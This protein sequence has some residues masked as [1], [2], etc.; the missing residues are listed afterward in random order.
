MD[1]DWCTEQKIM[2]S[3]AHEY[4]TYLFTSSNPSSQDISDIVTSIDPI[5]DSNM[6]DIL[7]APFSNDEVHRAVFDLH[8]SKSPGPDGFNALFYHKFWSVIG[9]DVTK[10]VLLILNGQGDI[11]YFYT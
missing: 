11:S 6:N 10:A 1:G 2:V 9:Q 5:V 8:P 4:F 3:I 7:C